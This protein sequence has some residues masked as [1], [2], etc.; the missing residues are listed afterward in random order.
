MQTVNI[1]NKCLLISGIVIFL[2][3]IGISISLYRAADNA[4][5][6]FIGYESGDNSSYPISPEDS[7]ADMRELERYG[8]KANVLAYEFRHFLSQLWLGKSAA[9]IVATFTVWLSFAIFYLADF[10]SIRKK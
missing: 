7:R 2:I 5:Q 10:L 6:D 8:G 4:A 9:I 1:R 3:G